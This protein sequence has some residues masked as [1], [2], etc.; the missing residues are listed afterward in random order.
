MV[1]RKYSLAERLNQQLT[2]SIRYWTYTHCEEVQING[3]CV[4]RQIAQESELL[5]SAPVISRILGK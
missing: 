4:I 5:A 1:E 2:A 3:F